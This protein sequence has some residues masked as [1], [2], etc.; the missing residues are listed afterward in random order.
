M[1]LNYEYLMNNNI[2]LIV[3]DK[4]VLTHIIKSCNEILFF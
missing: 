1:K 2:F 4:L 3:G